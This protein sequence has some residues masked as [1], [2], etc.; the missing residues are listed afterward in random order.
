M[1]WYLHPLKT[2]KLVPI[3]LKDVRLGANQVPHSL[4]PNHRVE[5]ESKTYLYHGTTQ[6][7]AR[8]RGLFSNHRPG[9]KRERI[10]GSQA[11][12][13]GWCRPRGV[14]LSWQTSQPR[15]GRS[16]QPRRG[17]SCC[18]QVCAAGG[19]EQRDQ[20]QG[21]GGG[22]GNGS[23]DGGSNGSDDGAAGR[24]AVDRQRT[25]EQVC[26]SWDSVCTGAPGLSPL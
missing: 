22:P 2:C 13:L 6:T 5:S 3:S 14:C 7:F 17:R 24:G 8:V 9:R 10:Y 4:C 1:F 11:Q 12:P 23:E 26:L 20:L 15:R 25:P 16:C 19:K 21:A 18:A